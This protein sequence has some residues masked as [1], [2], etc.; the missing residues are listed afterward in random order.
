VADEG[1]ADGEEGFVD[2]GAP[3]IATIEATVLVQP[4]ERALDHPAV[5]AES[6]SVCDVALGDPGR[7]AALPQRLAVAATVVCAV[8]EQRLGAELAVASGR[9]D[10]VHEREK[11]G[12]VVAVPAGQDHGQGDALALADQVVL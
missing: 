9:R 3:V 4:G 6:R 8:G 1:G 7:D 11:L 12:D 2:I 10:P 5:F